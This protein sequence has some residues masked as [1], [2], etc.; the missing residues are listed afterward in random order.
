MLKYT[1]LRRSVSPNSYRDHCFLFVSSRPAEDL[2][3][4]GDALLVYEDE[5]LVGEKEHVADELEAELKLLAFAQQRAEILVELLL[6]Y[7]AR[8]TEQS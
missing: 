4:W 8:I 7:C 1:W 6:T 2:R 5:A 3:Q